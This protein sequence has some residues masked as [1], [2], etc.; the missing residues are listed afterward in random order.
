MKHLLLLATVILWSGLGFLIKRW[1]QN[2]SKTFSQHAAA[3]RESIF[4]YAIL[5]CIVL[6]LTALYVV[7]WLIPTFHLSWTFTVFIWLAI[8]TQFIVVLIPETKGWRYS[9]HRFLAFWGA[10]FLLPTLYLLTA[11]Q[12]VSIAGRYTSATSL[13]IMIAIFATLVINKA[14]HKYFLI[15]QGSFFALYFVA[16][17]AVTYA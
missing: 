8:I 10:L 4:Y 15:L 5:F 2:I 11:N 6:P 12:G 3:Q 17:L 1:P 14:E 7:N 16:L 9:T 13:A